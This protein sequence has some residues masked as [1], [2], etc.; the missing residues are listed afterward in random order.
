[1][2]C[3]IVKATRA[4]DASPSAETAAELVKLYE[5]EKNKALFL[6]LVGITDKLNHGAYPVDDVKFPAECAK[7]QDGRPWG[8]YA[9]VC[10]WIPDFVQRA[11]ALSEFFPTVRIHVR[12]Y[13]NI[14]I[15]SDP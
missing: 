7:V 9:G 2:F 11:R 13:D 15:V 10:I 1:M 8:E 12:E 3:T 5:G 6:Y 14:L 4:F